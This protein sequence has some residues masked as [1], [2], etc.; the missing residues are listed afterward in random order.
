MRD[1]IAQSC[2]IYFFRLAEATELDP[3]AKVA[4]EFGLGTKTGIGVNPEASGRIPTRNWYSLHFPH[5]RYVPGYALNTAIGQGDVTVTPLQLAFAYAAIG[6]GGTLYQPQLVRAI[7]TSEH[8][9]VQEFPPRIRRRVNIRPENLARVEQGLYD[10]VNTEN[11]TANP[12]RDPTL[13]IAGKTGTA[14]VGHHTRRTTTTSGSPPGVS[15]T[16]AW[17]AAFS[18]SKAPEIAVVGAGRAW[19]SGPE[20]AHVAIETIREYI[21]LRRVRRKNPDKKECKKLGA[22]P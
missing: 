6:N 3:M 19:R 10:V 7:E 15:S 5:A 14:Q 16:H 13:D 12:A 18:P 21:D 17:F 22:K 11:G 20:V 9:V 1:A 2:N 4:M 8:D